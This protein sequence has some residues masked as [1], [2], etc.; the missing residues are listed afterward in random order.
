M[1]CNTTDNNNAPISSLPNEILTA[2]F[3][4]GSRHSRSPEYG[5]C[6]IP[7][8]FEI[9]VS[10][11]THHWRSV[12]ISMPRLW[13]KIWRE[14][15]ELKPITA[16]LQRSL[17]LP[18]DFTLTMIDQRYYESDEY[19]KELTPLFL[20]LEPHMGRCHQLSIQSGF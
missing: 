16:Y 15:R 5:S 7:D 9:A 1:E 6:W 20:L 13:T 14:P 3:E 17:G 2:I 11:V 4:I 19:E 18:F 10:H 8:R 12:A